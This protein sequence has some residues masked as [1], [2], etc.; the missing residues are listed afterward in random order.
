MPA[1]RLFLSL[2][3][4]ATVA[5]AYWMGRN[6]PPAPEEATVGAEDP[7]AV[8]MVPET[9]KAGES[10]GTGGEQVAGAPGEPP[11]ASTDAREVLAQARREMGPGMSS[12][13]NPSTMFRALGPLMTLPASEIRGALAEVSATVTDPQ[14]RAMF[15]SLLLSRWAEED[16]KAALEYA[17]KLVSGGGPIETQALMGVVSTWAKNEPEAAWN[18]Y[19]KRRNS[20]EAPLAGN[21][22]DTTLLAIFGAT[23][24]ND[25]DSALVKV[26]LLDDDSSR[27]MALMGIA[28][29]AMDGEKRM[30][31]LDRSKTLDPD[32]GQ[33]LRENVLSQWAQTEPDAV[34]DWLRAQ[35]AEERRAVTD[36]AAYA[37]ISNNPEKAAAFLMEDAT[38]ENLARRYSAIVSGWANRD[39]IA[40]GEWLNRQPKS[41]AQDQ[42]RLNFANQVVRM[43][44]EAAMEWAKS[45]TTEGTRQN[46]I[47]NVFQQW[48]RRDADA[49]NAALINS[50]LPA[51]KIE[52]IR[53][54]VKK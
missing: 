21:G 38:D 14:Q 39:P 43:D 25:L 44:P 53:K 26:S 28:F 29:T 13:L 54:Q 50:G 12:M 20:G 36:R 40:A 45:I 31:I 32:T 16:P 19:L 41:P 8:T 33:T 3:W 22:F 2:V 10:A 47:R 30:E 11:A 1:P 46:S 37:L 24:A 5:G 7:V 18:W 35:P 17:E 42:A 48:S 9:G 27:N 52:E 23:A 4:I 6:W 34:M 15:Q 51:E 49:A